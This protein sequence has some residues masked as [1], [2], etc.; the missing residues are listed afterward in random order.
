MARGIET[1]AADL[2]QALAERGQQILLC[3][4]AGKV[5]AP[6]E[7][8]VPCWTRDSAG[9]LRLL[10]WMPSSLG[11]RFGLGSGYAVEQTTF[12]RNLIKLLQAEKI[13]IL[14]VQD[15]HVA[16]TVQR[17]YER[18]RVRTRTILAHGTEEPLEFQARITW[19]QHLAPWHLEHARRH[20]VS[21]PGWTA[22]PNFI[23][24]A[25]F[26]PHGPNLRSEL[27][28]PDDAVVVLTAAAIK[29]RHKRIDSLLDEF[30]RLRAQRSDL[31]VYLVIAGG[32]E[33]E[34]DELMARGRE[35]LGD[36]VRFLVSF[37]RERMAELYRTGDIFV[38]CSLKEMMP[39]AL[40]EATACGL[41]CLINQHPV[42]TWMAGPGGTAIDMAT[43][44]ALSS[45][46]LELAENSRLRGDLGRNAQTWC[47][48]NFSRE[49]VVNQILDYYDFVMSA[50]ADGR[51]TTEMLP[52]RVQACA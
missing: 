32:R 4:G 51:G 17:A 43:P 36:R 7:R 9:T 10:R 18:G 1:W 49:T 30:S 25:A 52:S 45:A 29:K 44:G 37:P 3:K 19:V 47:R 22:I 41:P 23:D 31:P 26:R 11:W 5:T 2:G 13:D 14:H 27:E 24:P 38:L 42:V 39:I 12:A 21:R 46:L 15:P 6:F 34:T 20:G 35:Q 33:E 48:Q 28:L 50:G 8:I 16:M 40:L